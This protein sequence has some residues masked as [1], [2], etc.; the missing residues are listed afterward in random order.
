MNN[1]NQSEIER[2]VF[3]ISIDFE[4]IWGTLDLFGPDKFQSACKVE[5]ET[6][7][8][9]LLDLFAEFDISAT[10]CILGHLMLGRCGPENGYKH[11]EIVRPVHSW[12][13]MDWFVNDPGGSETSAPLF[14]GRSL[15]EMIRSCP[16]AQEIG[17][18]SFSH[19]IFGDI[20]CSRETAASEVSACVRAARE[21]GIEMRS[22]AFPRNV[23]GHLDVLREHGFACYRGPEQNWY[24]GS[25]WPTAVK[26]LCHLLDV[27]AA[28]TPQVVSPQLSKHGIWNIPGSMIYFPMHGIRRFLPN[29]LR[30]KRAIKGLDAAV[31]QKRI[32]HLWFHPTNFADEIDLMFTGLR[33]ILEHAACLRANDQL[34]IQPMGALVS[35]MDS[36]P[37]TPLRSGVTI[38]SGNSISKAI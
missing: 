19:V 38:S 10:W 23:V 7:V 8:D 4:L 31:K 29:S 11:P 20:G 22:F 25:R 3:T 14:F 16:V 15:V 2:G 27:I 30:V 37:A 6:V 21:L 34:S 28:T 1:H 36:I 26:R 12:H 5:R 18:H 9:R 13:Q 35:Q 17:S 32:F 24:F 33:R